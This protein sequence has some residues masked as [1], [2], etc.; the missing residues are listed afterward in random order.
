MKPAFSSTAKSNL[1]ITVDRQR[2]ETL[3]L[4]SPNI[5][6]VILGRDWLCQNA[7]VWEFAK[8]RIFIDGTSHTLRSR[9]QKSSYCKR[10]IA[11]T[12]VEIAP[13]S[14]ALIPAHVVYG[15]L[16]AARINT[17]WSTVLAEPVTGLRT[18]RT[19]VNHDSPCVFVRACNVTERPDTTTRRTDCQP[20]TSEWKLSNQ[21][22]RDNSQPQRKKRL[23]PSTPYWNEST[24][25]YR[26][27]T[28][29][30]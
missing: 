1:S 9:T 17:S 24:P 5:D 15:N 29:T 3:F 6:E 8:N 12:D 21:S 27:T 2:T 19:L 20:A 10:C 11:R 14:E 30:S 7:I 23:K 26:Q 22:E 28:K 16:K 13:L 25:T 18:A 4:A